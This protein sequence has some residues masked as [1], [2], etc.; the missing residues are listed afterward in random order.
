MYAR[1]GL[2]HTEPFIDSSFTTKVEVHNILG[3]PG[4]GGGV[5]HY[6]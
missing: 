2:E 3:I 6:A 1:C 5:P 4:S